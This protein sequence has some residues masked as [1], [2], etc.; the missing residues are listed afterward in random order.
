MTPKTFHG[1]I[2]P[3]DIA[4]SLYA[5]FHRGNLRVQQIMDG[6]NIVV[7]IAS[8]DQTQSGGKTGVSVSLQKVEDGVMVSL[9]KQAWM[10]I[11]SS[12]GVTAFSVFRNPL[13]ILGRIDDIAQ[14]IENIQLS[15]AIWD[16]I[17]A[18]AKNLGAGF[19]LSERLRRYVCAYCDTPNPMGEP[20]CIACG[21][22][23]GT[24][25]QQTCQ[26]CGYVLSSNSNVCP[27]CNKQL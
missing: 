25:Q 3:T 7:Q 18:T 20:R 6:N 14:D 21:A 24:S 26:F 4:S 2:T 17:E 12:L 23:L 8:R 19:E 27:N 22:P 16:V 1:K 5:H 15:D 10:G 13:N 11:A 9:G